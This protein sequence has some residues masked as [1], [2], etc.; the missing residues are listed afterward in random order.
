[1]SRL[2]LGV[3]IV[4][5]GNVDVVWSTIAD[6]V[7]VIE[8][9]P[10]TLW[11]ETPEGWT[12][13]VEA[14]DWIRSAGRP[15][16]AHG[17]G[18]PV[19]GQTP[20]NPAGVEAFARSVD[21]LH[22]V[23][24]S[25]HLAFNRAGDR[26]AG[27]LLPP[28]Q[29]PA[30]LAAAVEHIEAYQRQ[31]DVPFLVENA[32]SYVQPTAGEMSDGAFLSAVAEHSGCGL[33][34][35]LHNL[36]ANE[37]NGRGRVLDTVEELDCERVLEVHVAAGFWFQ[38][39]WLDA[40][41]G[42]CEPALLDLLGQ[43]LHRLPCVRA[44]IFEA[45]PPA[46]AEMGGGGVRQELEQ[47]QR[48]VAAARAGRLFGSSRRRWREVPGGGPAPLV[49]DERRR[50]A[51]ADQAAMLAYTTRQTMDPPTADV[52]YGVLREL[53]D[54]ARLGRVAIGVP[55]SVAEVANAVGPEGLDR[56]A[57]DFLVACDA[58][59]WTM[60]E[61]RAFEDFVAQRAVQPPSTTSV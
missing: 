36:L 34:L 20:P 37:R 42:P 59:D 53:T 21:D 19:G 25:E 7:D 38:G 33:L 54:Q 27:F 24:A 32:V 9:E 30:T 12:P 13:D 48:I 49:T 56:V 17:V 1:M 44:V 31:L 58:A 28:R 43:V 18:F 8:V 52:G 46:L 14:Y 51:A 11:A 50:D 5:L 39:L 15:V 22:A 26:H 3:G 55:E 10:Q 61:A 35:D 60:A 41:S 6:V 47:L 57:A 23:H 29:T 45:M 16:L 4:A 2:D 40:H